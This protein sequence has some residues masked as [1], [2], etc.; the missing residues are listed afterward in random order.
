[1]SEERATR[2]P[3]ATKGP[4]KRYSAARALEILGSRQTSVVSDRIAILGNLCNDKIRLDT[5]KIYTDE[6][7][8]SVC[9]LTV[10]ILNG[11]MSL[12]PGFADQA[13]GSRNLSSLE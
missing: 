4:R 7:S 12:L 2:R 5:A 10:A 8:F 9:A 6:F 3:V 11:D 13:R 1:M